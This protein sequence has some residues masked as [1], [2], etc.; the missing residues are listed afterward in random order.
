MKGG[1]CHRYVISS[2]EGFCSGYTLIVVIYLCLYFKNNLN[3]VKNQKL[4][5]V[6]QYCLGRGVPNAT[7]TKK[8]NDISVCHVLTVVAGKIP[9]S[10]L[11]C[12]RLCFVRL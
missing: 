8:V 1:I 11:E 5:A 3:L 2:T 12:D 10:D 7:G 4:K 6:G 9:P